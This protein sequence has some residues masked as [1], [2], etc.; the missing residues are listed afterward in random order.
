[1]HKLLVNF[2]FPPCRLIRNLTPTNQLLQLDVRTRL[3]IRDSLYR[4]AQNAMQRHHANG[5][6]CN[7][8]SGRDENKVAKE[9]NK[10]CNR[11]VNSL[12]LHLYLT[13][14]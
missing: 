11:L 8:K 13:Q 2:F 9:E 5:T 10:N 1:M 7:N 4:L 6:S 14:K 12:L 3:C